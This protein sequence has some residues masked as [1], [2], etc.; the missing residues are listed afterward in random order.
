MA[1][2]DVGLQ[3]GSYPEQGPIVRPHLFAPE[4]VLVPRFIVVAGIRAKGAHDS[5]QVMGILEADML[6]DDR[7]AIH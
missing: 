6:F 1:F 7:Q 4:V 5:V 3:V 2:L